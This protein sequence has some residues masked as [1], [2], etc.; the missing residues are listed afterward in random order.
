MKECQKKK[1]KGRR[2]RKDEEEEAE[3]EEHEQDA[4]EEVA[5]QQ[6]V[7]CGSATSSHGHRSIGSTRCRL[8]PWLRDTICG[9]YRCRS[10]HDNAS[11]R[12]TAKTKTEKT[13]VT[14]PKQT[15]SQFWK[16]RRAL[17]PVAPS[18]PTEMPVPTHVP[19]PTSPVSS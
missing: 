19:S 17:H 1:K 11:T 3:E 13:R 5:A 2:R 10:R 4:P 16:R 9:P 6:P 18:S 12:N 14:S 15:A 7:S 8:S